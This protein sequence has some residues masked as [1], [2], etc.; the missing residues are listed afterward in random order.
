MRIKRSLRILI[1]SCLT[2]V[3]GYAFRAGPLFAWSP[4]KPGYNVLRLQRADVYFGKGAML[5][6][7]F[8][9]VD[10][11][12]DE[13][14]KF[15]QLSL[16]HRMTIIVCRWCWSVCHASTRTPCETCFRCHGV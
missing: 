4:I 15:H 12:I 16:P 10:R 1:L 14:E 11:Y 5:D 13:T 9:N 7:A 8:R 3:I 2:I 6:P